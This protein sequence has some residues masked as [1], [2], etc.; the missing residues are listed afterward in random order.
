M[1]NILNNIED[2][3][4]KLQDMG[5]KAVGNAKEAFEKVGDDFEQAVEVAKDALN[6]AIG[7]LSPSDEAPSE[8]V[9]EAPEKPL[10]FEEK[11]DQEI[12]SQV[13]AIRAAQQTPGAFSD[14]IS[15]KFGKDK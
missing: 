5:E 11:L 7:S 6:R 15:K 2:A 9:P 10:T 4:A 12:S 14:Y 3:A 1:R 8:P 13:N